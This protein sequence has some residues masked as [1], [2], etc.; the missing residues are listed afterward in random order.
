MIEPRKEMMYH[1]VTDIGD[2]ERM[3]YVREEYYKLYRV[4]KLNTPVNRSQSI[5]LTYLEDS[6]LRAIQS[7]AIE[8][9]EAVAPGA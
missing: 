2:Q 6:L 7:I 8:Y 5:A 1:K 4:I 9:G 3:G